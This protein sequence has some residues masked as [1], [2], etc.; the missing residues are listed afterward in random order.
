MGVKNPNVKIIGT[1]NGALTN[2][3]C[4]C[5]DCGH[6]WEAKPEKLVRGTG[7]P[8]CFIERRRT[9]IT[10][11]HEEF[12]EEM[13]VKNSKVKIIGKYVNNRTIV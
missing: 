8:K 10:R 1:Y 9:K 7:C 5:K 3:E 11:T 13:K 4:Q 2:I 6:V 12:V